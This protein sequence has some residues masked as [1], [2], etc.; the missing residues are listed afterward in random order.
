MPSCTI[1]PCSY[2]FV[3]LFTTHPK[4][5]NI[6]KSLFDILPA[7]ITLEKSKQTVP[8]SFISMTEEATLQRL[9]QSRESAKKGNY[10]DAETMVSDIRGKYGL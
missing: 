8:E 6:A 3:A 9:Q 5:L 10:R 7:D 2:F 1:Q 4:T